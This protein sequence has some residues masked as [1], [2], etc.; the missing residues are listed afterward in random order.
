RGDSVRWGSPLVFDDAPGVPLALH[1]AVEQR[2]VDAL[3]ARRHHRTWV[4]RFLLAD[5]Y[6][7]VE[8]ARRHSGLLV[9]P[10]LG[11]AAGQELAG[12]AEEHRRPAD[13]WMTR[14]ARRRSG[15]GIGTG[16]A[17][18]V[19]RWTISSQRDARAI[20]RSDGRAPRN[21]RSTSPAA[22]RNTSVHVAPYEM[23]PP[24]STKSR[25]AET[26]GSPFRL[27]FVAI[28]S[29]RA[30]VSASAST[31]RACARCSLILTNISRPSLSA[32]TSE[33]TIST[34]WACAAGCVAFRS[35]A[36]LPLAGFQSAA[37]R[38]TPGMIC[39]SSSIRRALS[40]G[41]NVVSP[42]RFELAAGSPVSPA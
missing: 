10:L 39:R 6:V 38:V 21:I 3:R 16:I 31:M 34:F 1:A 42:V 12:G 17:R 13:H 7:V 22:S 33:G 24:A 37:T 27:A 36:A 35:T 23:R 30:S 15:S 20:G 41:T 18:A 26:D 2:P 19:R 11:S 28:V 9:H 29:R 14:S 32:L 40:S 8:L 25:S 5:G 4:G